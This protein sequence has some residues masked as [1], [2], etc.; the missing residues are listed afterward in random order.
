M[1][2]GEGSKPIQSVPLLGGPIVLVVGDE[3][4]EMCEL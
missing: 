1:N 3:G 4:E 2:S